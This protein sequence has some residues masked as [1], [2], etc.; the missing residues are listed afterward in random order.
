MRKV[1][2]Y[3]LILKKGEGEVQLT[4]HLIMG[5]TIGTH[6]IA[7]AL[8]RRNVNQILVVDE[9]HEGSPHMIYGVMYCSEKQAQKICKEYSNVIYHYFS[10]PSMTFNIQH[11]HFR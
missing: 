7:E 10:N 11:F 6:R 3:A 8:K 1:L 4:I 9:Y 2:S 5:M